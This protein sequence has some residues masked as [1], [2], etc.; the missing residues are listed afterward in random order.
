MTTITVARDMLESNCYCPRQ[1]HY[2]KR[3]F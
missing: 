1:L 2:W 3:M